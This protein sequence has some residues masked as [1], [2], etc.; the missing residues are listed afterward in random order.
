MGK[1]Y[2]HLSDWERKRMFVWFHYDKKSIREIGRLLE[3]SH[4]TISRELKRNISNSKRAFP[5]HYV[6]TWY[7]NPANIYYKSRIRNRGRR[8]RL[9]T[10]EIRNYVIDK[11][12]TGWSPE[13]ISGRLRNH[14][15]LGYVCH[16]SIYQFIYHEAPELITFL[17]RHHKKRRQKHPYRKPTPAIK[18]KTSILEREESINSRSEYGHWESDSIESKDRK[19]AINVLVERKTRLT[20][21]TKLYSKTSEVTKNAIVK[22]LS[23]YNK[24]FIQSITYDNGPENA[25]HYIVNQLLKTKSYFCQ[26]YH[27]WEK[28]S[29]EQVNGLIRRI[30]P[31]RTDFTSVS[32]NELQRLENL[33][34]SRP[35]KCLGYKTPIEVYNEFTTGA[36]SH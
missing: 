23:I 30:F 13:I 35:R 8:L 19:V 36:L 29:V 12:K 1:H 34:N 3:R 5:R 22:R 33:L 28:G 25:K 18:Q 15:E 27:S 2:S 4:T 32:Q 9:K 10:N 7:P 6:D 24:Q 20:H 21:I 31:K 14:C 11:I 16:E 17:P 26:P